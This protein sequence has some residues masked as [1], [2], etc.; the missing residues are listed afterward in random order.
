MPG[1]GKAVERDYTPKEREAIAGGANT[2]GLSEEHVLKL[3]GER[4]LDVYLNDTAYWRNLP[5]RV[6]EYTIGGYQVIKKWLSYRESPILG[7]GLTMDE[8]R[9]VTEIA[10]RIA[11]II[12]MEPELDANYQAVK[13]SSYAWP[14]AS[15]ADFTGH[16]E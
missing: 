3:I 11:A 1:K 9:T 5:V 8:V 16:I 10:R 6:W 15:G 4:T 12:L 14:A 13:Q 7:R 2:M